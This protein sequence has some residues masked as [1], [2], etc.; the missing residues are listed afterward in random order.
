MFWTYYK[1]VLVITC[2]FRPAVDI[3]LWQGINKCKNRTE[4]ILSVIDLSV[5]FYIVRDFTTMCLVSH[6]IYAAECTVFAHECYG[7][8]TEI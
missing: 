3:G 4:H 8:G 7:C 1:E 5:K 6:A 2:S